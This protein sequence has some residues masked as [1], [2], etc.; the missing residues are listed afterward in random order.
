MIIFLLLPF[1][2]VQADNNFKNMQITEAINELAAIKNK[3]VLYISKPVGS[4]TFEI[5]LNKEFDILLKD[6][7]SNTNYQFVKHNNY[8][9]IGIFS[10][11]S[12]EFANLSDTI[13]Y[14]T[15]YLTPEILIDKLDYPNVKIKPLN[16]EKE[17][18]IQGLPSD[19]E[20]IKEKIVKLDKKEN[21]PQIQY[22]LTLIDITTESEKRFNLE[23]IT[24]S[25]EKNE[26]FQFY[27]SNKVME[28]ILE[29]VI[30]N[31]SITSDNTMEKTM[32]V[33]SPAVVTEIGTTGSIELNEELITFTEEETIEQ[34]T[35]F[36][37]EL[38]P[39]R[40]SSR[41]EI[42]TNV[43]INSN[44][45]VSF[46]TNLWLE[47]NKTELIG[48]FKINRSKN[49][50]KLMGNTEIENKRVY[51]VYIT[52]RPVTSSPAAELNGL[53]QIIFTD[54]K[55]HYN[56]SNYIQFITDKNFNPNLD[57]SFQNDKTANTILLK[58]R[59][60][61]E[62][63]ELGYAINLVD[64]LSLDIKAIIKEDK[65]NK[66]A[67]GLVDKVRVTDNLNFTAGYYP[68]VV[69]IDDGEFTKPFG[70]I[71]TSYMPDPLSFKLRYNYNIE[72]NSLQF[73][74]GYK[75]NKKLELITAL[76]GN[77]EE[78][79]KVLAGIKYNF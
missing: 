56:A 72:K 48:L 37:T 44:Q 24:A 2:H 28:V 13:V 74:T 14:E 36:S 47:S 9:I 71:E 26:F 60:G 77:K 22:E 57:L 17:I 30:N 19:V 69:F 59:D 32:E 35:T 15:K 45:G 42:K 25:S 66:S 79:N 29:E 67:L 41:G 40:L 18:L 43:I 38:T 62:H 46:S 5:D 39:E 52:A 6:I 64:T 65:E 3:N 20:K 8:Y 10:K 21:F 78:M 63:L 16:K 11:E 12:A 4:L 68:L 33:A 49:N 61:T 31:I 23:E 34:E 53:D 55:P 7:L 76:W 27:K 54:E 58:T 73:E 75:V 70:F 50:E 1:S 51:A